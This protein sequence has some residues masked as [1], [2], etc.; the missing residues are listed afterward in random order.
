MQNQNTNQASHAITSHNIHQN[1]SGDNNQPVAIS[2]VKGDLHI[3]SSHST[4]TYEP[5]KPLRFTSLFEVFAHYFWRALIPLVIASVTA[6]F[7][8]IQKQTEIFAKIGPFTFFLNPHV[9]HHPSVQHA[10][11]STLSVII[12]SFLSMVLIT[13]L[14]YKTGA[15]FFQGYT[16]WFG[17]CYVREQDGQIIKAKYEGKCPEKTCSGKVTVKQPFENKERVKVAGVCNRAKRIHTYQF[18]PVTSKGER[19]KLTPVEEKKPVHNHHHHH[20]S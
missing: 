19:I 14:I 17:S 20:S 2:D 7:T 15:L 4:I 16:Y 3:N 18:D 12:L 1:I 9:L 13:L 5:H 6:Y 10:F 11:I 8:D